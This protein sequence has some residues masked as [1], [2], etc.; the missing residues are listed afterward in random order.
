MILLATSDW[1]L[2]PHWGRLA[3][4]CEAAGM[5]GGTSNSKGRGSLP[6]YGGLLPGRELLP[7][8]KESK[9]LQISFTSDGRKGE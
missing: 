2:Q 5:R 3:A 1:D 6:G 8:E 7:Q 4:G 9:D